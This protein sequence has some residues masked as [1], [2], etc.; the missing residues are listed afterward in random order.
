MRTAIT[1]VLLTLAA[2]SKLGKTAVASP[3]GA[4]AAPATAPASTDATPAAVPV[5]ADNAD[6]TN[7]SNIDTQVT[8]TDAELEAL[9][10]ASEG[11]EDDVIKAQMNV[12]LATLAHQNAVDDHNEAVCHHALEL[13]MSTMYTCTNALA[14]GV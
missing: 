8:T 1:T 3:A 2:A 7:F 13:I 11:F 4:D 10:A 14:A 9:E 5:A 12:D 6:Y